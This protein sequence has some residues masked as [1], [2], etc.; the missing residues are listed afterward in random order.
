VEARR[1]RETLVDELRDRRAK[2]ARA[3]GGMRIDSDESLDAL[4]SVVTLGEPDA[5]PHA[6]RVAALA[7]GVARLMGLGGPEV[8]TIERGALLHDL[9]KLAMPEALLRKPAPLSGDEQRLVRLIPVIGG[10]LLAS[11]PFLADAGTVVR[12]VHER[13]DGRG[14]PFGL[15]G[16][17][18]CLGARIVAV[19]DAY[20]TMTRPRIFRDA[21]GSAEALLELE[22]CAGAQFDRGVVGLFRRVLSIH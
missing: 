16:D 19:A 5:Y 13:I 3:V 22:R 2:L 15:R 20:D 21:I 14:H 8:A 10:E 9:G 1:W 7:V 17:E 18:I 6:Y 11:V 4:L 12:E